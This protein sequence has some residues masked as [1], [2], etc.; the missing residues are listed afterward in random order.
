[1]NSEKKKVYQRNEF[2]NVESLPFHLGFVLK[3]ALAFLGAGRLFKESFSLSKVDDSQEKFR[4]GDFSKLMAL[5]RKLAVIYSP[6]DAHTRVFAT[7]NQKRFIENEGVYTHSCIRFME[8]LANSGIFDLSK[9]DQF[10]DPDDLR[11]QLIKF[12]W[13]NECLFTLLSEDTRTRREPSGIFN[14]FNSEPWIFLDKQSSTDPK[15][16]VVV[17]LVLVFEKI[18]EQEEKTDIDDLE[19]LERLAYASQF[20]EFDR[21]PKDPRSFSLKLAAEVT[22]AELE[23]LG[24]AKKEVEALYYEVN[25][26][27]FQR[28]YRWR[29]NQRSV[30]TT[31]EV[32]SDVKAEAA[33]AE[34]A[35][36][37]AL[38]VQ[39]ETKLDDPARSAW[40]KKLNAAWTRFFEHAG[41][42]IRKT[43]Q[44]MQELQPIFRRQL[45]DLTSLKTS[46]FGKLMPTQMDVQEIGNKHLINGTS[47]SE[48]DYNE[49]VIFDGQALKEYFETTSKFL[50]ENPD[51]R[52]V[53][54]TRN[55]YLIRK[56]GS[57]PGPL[58]RGLENL[59]HPITTEG[60]VLIDFGKDPV[61][62][63]RPVELSE[64]QLRFVADLEKQ[65]GLT[66]NA[67]RLNAS[68]QEQHDSLL[69]ELEVMLPE[70]PCCKGTSKAHKLDEAFSQESFM[71]DIFTQGGAVICTNVSQI[72]SYT[73]RQAP[74]GHGWSKLLGMTKAGNLLQRG[75][76]KDGKLVL[77]LTL[78][79][80]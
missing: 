8:H 55:S 69:E 59:S 72:L 17:G 41:T 24:I 6:L 20:H 76:N 63:F 53:R 48:E 25:N 58:M 56:D 7:P 45:G 68:V 2:P 54:V 47:P 60:D 37:L 52:N 11:K 35:R 43:N 62:R 80:Q 28:Q 21:R 4:F 46:D 57:T 70:C 79:D 65:R 50:A 42:R 75:Y 1:M 66:P 39:N 19:V 10:L 40:I 61:V 27:E 78:K 30:A 22:L 23:V 73:N 26:N 44:F 5:T 67:L 49:T 64:D 34:M 15:A 33:Q 38:Y 31:L 29:I 3:L 16:K 74:N 36:M 51:R 77:S 9:F 71:Q 12:L 32:E 18:V 13:D 14:S